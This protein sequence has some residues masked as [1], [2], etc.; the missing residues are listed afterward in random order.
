MC[1]GVMFVP[2]VQGLFGIYLLSWSVIPTSGRNNNL[3]DWFDLRVWFEVKVENCQMWVTNNLD[4]L[5][6]LY[7]N[8]TR[9]LRSVRKH[10]MFIVYSQMILICFLWYLIKTRYKL[11]E[12]NMDIFFLIVKTLAIKRQVMNL[13]VLG[14]IPLIP[15]EGSKYKFLC[16]Y[17]WNLKVFNALK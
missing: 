14:S 16:K 15:L 3:H 4:E 9:C 11:Y 2:K 13:K 5:I 6:Y 1:E 17:F 7:M 12:Y 8:L 10:D